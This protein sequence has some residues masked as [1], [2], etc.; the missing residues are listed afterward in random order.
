MTLLR[1]LAELLYP[2]KCLH[3]RSADSKETAWCNTPKY[4]ER[5]SK[6]RNIPCLFI[7][8][9]WQDGEWPN[10]KIIVRLS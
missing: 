8:F 10:M 6:N 2:L 9:I 4:G 7:H 1:V 3:V 5:P